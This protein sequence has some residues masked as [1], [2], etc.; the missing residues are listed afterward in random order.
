MWFHWLLIVLLYIL[1][2]R[3]K[4]C[5]YD[6][7]TG[8]LNLLRYWHFGWFLLGLCSI[9]QIRRLMPKMEAS[10]LLYMWNGSYFSQS[11]Q[12]LGLH[13]S[14]KEIESFVSPYQ[15]KCSGAFLC[16]VHQTQFMKQFK[17]FTRKGKGK[18]HW[19]GRS[20]KEGLSLPSS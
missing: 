9:D 15:S 11:K 19:L 4:K 20:Y 14:H 17:H 3:S 16:C 8:K 10:S 18:K 6:F 12:H 13:T 7:L 1:K 5:E 2:M